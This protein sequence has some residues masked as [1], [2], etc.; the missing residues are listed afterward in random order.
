MIPMEITKAK[1]SIEWAIPVPAN[2]SINHC[3]ISKIRFFSLI[4]MSANLKQILPA[5]DVFQA[6]KVRVILLLSKKK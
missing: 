2:K 6:T 1:T 4:G 5:R 3:I